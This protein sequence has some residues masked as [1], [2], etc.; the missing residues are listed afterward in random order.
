MVNTNEG[1]R[2][3]RTASHGKCLSVTWRITE[4]DSDLLFKT[5][6]DTL[7]EDLQMHHQVKEKTKKYLRLFTTDRN[8]ENL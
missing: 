6:E 2:T 1:Q 7:E 4:Q 3:S 8:I 5:K